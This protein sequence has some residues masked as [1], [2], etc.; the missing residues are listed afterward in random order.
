MR[1]DVVQEVAAPRE[2]VWK[3]LT[4]WER[5]P[6]WML[7]AK[8][9][10]VLTPQR[11]GEGVTIRCPTRLLGATVQDIMRV[12]GWDPPR[13]LEVTH[14][15]R[16]ITGV[17]AFELTGAGAITEVCWWEEIDPPLGV[18]GEAGARLVVRPIV[19]RI[20]ARSLARFAALC[21]ASGVASV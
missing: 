17:G 19:A 15:G 18:V 20:F 8:S 13:Y 5:Q 11:T 21:E 12:T 4:A 6:E 9:V 3:V 7:D 14:L 1:V 16:V 2:L 10:A